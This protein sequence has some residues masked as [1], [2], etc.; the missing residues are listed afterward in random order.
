MRKSKIESRGRAGCIKVWTLHRFV[1]FSAPF[2][3][4]H[5]EARRCSRSRRPYCLDLSRLSHRSVVSCPL[6]A[7]SFRFIHGTNDA[8]RNS[9]MKTFA[10]GVLLSLVLVAQGFAIIRPPYPAKP[11]PPYQGRFIIIGD[12]A[13]SQTASKSPK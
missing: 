13:K 8:E 11:M 2:S 3:S 1:I 10:L 5:A 7:S 9:N 12:D 6:S 4:E